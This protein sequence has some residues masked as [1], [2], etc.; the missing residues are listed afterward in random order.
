[1]FVYPITIC[2]GF[3]LFIMTIL[4]LRTNGWRRLQFFEWFSIGASIFFVFSGFYILMT[5]F[6]RVTP[7]NF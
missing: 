3:V 2:F 6:T 7:F 5:T 4:S 1:M